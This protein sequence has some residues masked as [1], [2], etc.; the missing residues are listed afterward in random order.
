[1]PENFQEE[2]YKWALECRYMSDNYLLG[3]QITAIIALLM[4]R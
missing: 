1:M 2:L 4:L 3:T